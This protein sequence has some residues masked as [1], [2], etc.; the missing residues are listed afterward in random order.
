[1]G[2]SR[3]WS[4]RTGVDRADLATRWQLYLLSASEPLITL[5]LIGGERQV[6]VWAGAALL[7]VTAAHTTAC[8]LLLRAG[9][10][11]M[12]GGPR[13][14]P[15][16]V[17]LAV[18]LTAAA[19]AAAVA[20]FPAGRAEPG[21][22]HLGFP[23]GAMAL[24]LCGALTGAATPLLP[25]R[26]LLAVVALPAALAGGLQIAI[27]G[28][29]RP[30][31]GV[32]YLLCV[33]PAAVAY[34]S[35]VWI[36]GMMW[37]LDRA[38][39]V[40]AR[41]AVA[42]ERLR[43]SRDLHDVL[44]RN[45]AFI[46]VSS[47]LAAQLARRGQTGAV[48]HMLTVQATAQDSMREMREVVGGYRSA[49]LDTELAGARSLLRSAGIGVRVIGDGTA[50]PTAAQAALGWVVREATTNIIRHSQ[51]TL[52]TIEVDIR[53]DPGKAPAAELRIEND[54]VPVTDTSP[55]ESGAGTGLVGLRQRLED[56]GGTVTAQALPSGRFLLL[57]RLPLTQDAPAATAPGKLNP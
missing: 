50:L 47:E 56:L 27:A 55:A 20:A 25:G 8:L 28:T 57:A 30:L 35:V 24:L 11:H 31:W 52:V 42:E 36:L 33:G 29:G 6:R 49:D 16:L 1:M 44:G 43:F 54:G 14:S 34:R 46:T 21:P 32:N 3:W 51:P 37:E 19:L 38:R 26:R 9:I 22:F 13:P 17:G 7:A 12:L 40:Q 53:R 18:A 39:G 41:L 48:E 23:V 15:R 10:T 45:L 4:G 2:I 5:L